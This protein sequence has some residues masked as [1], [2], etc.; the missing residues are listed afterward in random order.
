MVNLSRFISRACRVEQGNYVP[1]KN[2]VHQP[3]YEKLKE[4]SFLEKLQK[5]LTPFRLPRA[6]L[7]EITPELQEAIEP[8]WRFW[9][10][11]GATTFVKMSR[12]ALMVARL[13]RLR[14]QLKRDPQARFYRD[15]ALTQWWK[16]GL[17]NSSLRRRQQSP[18][19][20]SGNGP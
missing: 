5:F 13:I 4:V 12:I 18:R 19:P 20:Q 2:A 8:A 14:H 1:P 9:P 16:T 11:Y 6:L 3:I 7:P 10:V 15:L 17:W